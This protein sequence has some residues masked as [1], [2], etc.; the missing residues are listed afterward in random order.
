MVV[1][2]KSI[3]EEVLNEIKAIT[4]GYTEY[5]DITQCGLGITMAWENNLISEKEVDNKI[6]EAMNCI[7]VIDGLRGFHL[8][9]VWN[10][11]GTNGWNMIEYVIGLREGLFN[12]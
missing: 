6:L 7:Q 10:Q 8:D 4:D 11:L 2:P 1:A 3:C 5:Q 9:R 12:F